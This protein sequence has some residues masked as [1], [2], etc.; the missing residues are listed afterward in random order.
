MQRDDIRELRREVA[1]AR[2]A[3]QDFWPVLPD[4]YGAGDPE[5]Y[6]L[7][8][9][10]VNE[11]SGVTAGAT[12]DIDNV[13][14]LAGGLNPAASTADGVNIEVEQAAGNYTDNQT[15]IRAAY[16][17]D[18]SRWIDVTD[19]S[20]DQSP[21]TYNVQLQA[22]KTK[23]ATT[24]S[25]KL[26][27][28]DLTTENGSSFTAYDP[29]TQFSSGRLTGA[30]GRI[31]LVTDP[32]TGAERW[33]LTHCQGIAEYVYGTLSEDEGA[34]TAGEASS[35]SYSFIS[36][37]WHD[38]DPAVTINVTDLS[39]QKSGDA[40]FARLENPDTTPRKYRAM[41]V[42]PKGLTFNVKVQEA[43][44]YTDGDVSVKW[45]E[46]DLS[47]E[48]GSAFDAYDPHGQFSTGGL[49][50]VFGRVT[51]VID[52]TTQQARWE[53]THLEG[54][55]LTAYGTLAEDEGATS[56][57]KASSS[58]FVT[59]GIP[60]NESAPSGSINVVGLDGETTGDAYVAI[61]SDPD[62]SPPEYRAV[63][64]PSSGNTDV[65]VKV[66]SSETSAGYLAD[67][68]VNTGTLTGG[69][70]RVYRR[71]AG[72]DDTIYFETEAPAGGSPQTYNVKLQAAKA[73]SATSVNVKWVDES[74][75]E[76]DTA[77]AAYD[78]HQQ[79]SSG[80]NSGAFGR[81]ALVTDPD[82]ETER[83]EL[84][85]LEG[86]A[87][88]A[89]GTLAENEG[90]TSSGKASSS[91]YSAFGPKW[92]EASPA[93]SINITGLDGQQSG[94]AYVAVLEDGEASPPEY[95]A[96]KVP[97]ANTD[98]LVKVNSSETSAG[99]LE[100]QLVNSGTL[101]SGYQRVYFRKNG[102]DSM[103]AE[104]EEASGGSVTLFDCLIEYGQSLSA[105]S[106]DDGARE[107][108]DGSGTVTL[109]TDNGDGTYDE[110]G[111]QAVKW[112]PNVAISPPS[113]KAYRGHG[114]VVSGVYKLEA[115]YS[116][117]GVTWTSGS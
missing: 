89:V 9:G 67:Q 15:K 52:A 34:T 48:V 29:H 31:A 91:S 4:G 105:G 6:R 27:E 49:D 72:D 103:Y 96:V 116:C 107:W 112:R 25:V 64:T 63:K 44:A 58:S 19:Q 94:D 60:W 2:Q 47:T 92:Q 90:A 106:W 77:F 5:T 98:V 114:I 38:R 65:L 83:W 32:D 80:D 84:T 111:T 87:L 18:N 45:L 75:T 3:A 28:D 69:Y 74:L 59:E 10:T 24:I 51:M 7:I 56:S 86:M 115:V 37:P 22:I 71:V 55:A 46:D 50:D 95:R 8:E 26:L 36:T 100:D 70:Q 99:Y 113:G 85:H 81:I 33:E 12:F 43:K 102:N 110:A 66:N 104:T 76:Y 1:E 41:R 13:R 97:D 14:P 16:D 68:I 82:D 17:E 42:P 35:S 40:Y 93:G 20:G 39:G 54:L 11:A 61:L 30:K 108:T 21:Q 109:L 78:P 101:T 73:K 79:F 23:A 57:G 117:E 62:A 88:F 53:L